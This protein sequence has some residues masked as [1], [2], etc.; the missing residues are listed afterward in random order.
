MSYGVQILQRLKNFIHIEEKP[1]SPNERIKKQKE[2]AR[3]AQIAE[4]AQQKEKKRKQIIKHQSHIQK[5]DI[6]VNVIVTNCVRAID[7]AAKKGLE[8]I[9]AYIDLSRKP[10]TY[11]TEKH[12]KAVV[13]ALTACGYIVTSS[14][15]PCQSFD[16]TTGAKKIKASVNSIPGPRNGGLPKVRKTHKLHSSDDSEYS[17]EE[18]IY[19]YYCI[20]LP[21]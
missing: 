1:L 17:D 16:V 14:C 7:L 8:T 6:H 20:S 4:L 2:E 3:L 10:V 18:I 13:N 11:F 9:I 15:G 12:W 19:C 5:A 21:D